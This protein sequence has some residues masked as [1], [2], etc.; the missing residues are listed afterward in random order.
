MHPK[1]MELLG[2]DKAK[3]DFNLFGKE[4]LLKAWPD[5]AIKCLHGLPGSAHLWLP[6][7]MHSP[8]G[9][10]EHHPVNPAQPLDYLGCFASFVPEYLAS[11]DE[12]QKRADDIETGHLFNHIPFG[13]GM[14]R[15]LLA[16]PRP[17]KRQKP[18]SSALSVQDSL[19]CDE[20]ITRG[21]P[22]SFNAL[23]ELQ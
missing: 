14:K 20:L 10:Q 16:F 22:I 7:M 4:M 15:S 19:R 6:K 2:R 12:L 18:A 9:A 11:R 23:G 3:H 8:I 17:A 5:P 1:F 21:A 13:K